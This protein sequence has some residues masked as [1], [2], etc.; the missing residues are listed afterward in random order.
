MTH[1]WEKPVKAV[2][3]FFHLDDVILIGGSLGGNLVL[4]AADFEKR[5]TKV[6]CFDIFPDLFAVSLNQ[7]PSDFRDFVRQNVLANT[8]RDELNQAENKEMNNNLTV[9]WAVNQGMQVMGCE[10]PYD[11]LRKTT[12]FRTQP[13]SDKVT[14]DVLLLAGQKDHYVPLEQLSQQIQSLTS[15]HSLTARVFTTREQAA[16]HCQVGNTGLALQTMLN[17]LDTENGRTN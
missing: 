16:D 12:L 5:V 15:V 9:Q 1:K 6:I 2:L 3:D 17:W 13:I 14:Q 4:R 7:I 11:F 10:T 8:G